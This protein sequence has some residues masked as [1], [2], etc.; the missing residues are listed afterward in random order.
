MGACLAFKVQ[1]R[2]RASSLR[3]SAMAGAYYRILLLFERASQ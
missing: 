2:L 3:V 1:G